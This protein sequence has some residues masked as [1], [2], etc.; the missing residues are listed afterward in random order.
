M[1]LFTV[2]VAILGHTVLP[3]KIMI[4]TIECDENSLASMYKVLANDETILRDAIESNPELLTFVDE[5]GCSML[6]HV[7]AS[8]NKE[9]FSLL[10]QQKGINL[11]AKD[12][13]HNTPLHVSC[14]YGN[15]MLSEILIAKGCSVNAKNNMHCSPLD[16][17]TGIDLSYQ[18]IV[19]S[20][21]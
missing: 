12:I 3:T 14:Y 11:H 9:C 10:L 8:G 1:A 20:H 19:Y 16:C 5:K 7:C 4:T 13:N 2:G 18:S 15:W 6:H 17:C 21:S